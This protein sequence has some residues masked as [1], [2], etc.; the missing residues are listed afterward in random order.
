VGEAA[1]LTLEDID[2][3]RAEVRVQRNLVEVRGEV[4]IGRPKTQ[5]SARSVALPSFV[6]EAL[7]S[8]VETFPTSVEGFVF[9]G[10]E[11]GPLR[12][13]LFRRRVWHP[14]LKRCGTATPLPRIHDLRHS[15]AAIAIQ[16]GAHPKLI[17]AMLGH[18]SITTSLDRYGHLFSSVGEELARRVDELGRDSAAHLPRERREEVVSLG[19]DGDKRPCDLRRREVGRAGIEPATSCLSSIAVSTAC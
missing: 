7:Q 15:A 5:A 9:S 12:R 19:A 10:P 8:H 1:A 2:L 13:S 18:D 11:G 6:R 4:T 16:A 14:A 3:L 17:Q